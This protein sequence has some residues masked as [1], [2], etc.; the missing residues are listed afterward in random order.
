MN[1]SIFFIFKL[2]CAKI[3]ET[4]EIRYICLKNGVRRSFLFLLG[5][6]IYFLNG[7]SIL[8]GNFTLFLEITYKAKVSGIQGEN[9]HFRT[10]ILITKI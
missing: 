2:F 4:R 3:K 7:F 1:D 5:I 10:N 8:H 9:I 6:Y